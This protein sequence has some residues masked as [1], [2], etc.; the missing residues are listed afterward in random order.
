MKQV[1]TSTRIVLLTAV[2]SISACQ[3]VKMPNLDVIK[4]PE[5]SEDA[6]NIERSYPRPVDAP[7][8]PQDVRS[9][10]QWDKDAIALQRLRDLSDKAEPEPVLS[11]KDIEDRYNALKDKAQAYKDDDPATETDFPEV[12]TRRRRN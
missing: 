10:A 7:V 12:D 9:G 1:F 3:T 6:A 5:F 2:L 8:L 4:S 11:E